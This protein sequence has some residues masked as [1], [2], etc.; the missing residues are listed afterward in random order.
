M[1]ELS[2]MSQGRTSSIRV[3]P[4]LWRRPARVRRHGPTAA[5]QPHRHSRGPLVSHRSSL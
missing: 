3:V 4:A 2:N 5:P 1:L